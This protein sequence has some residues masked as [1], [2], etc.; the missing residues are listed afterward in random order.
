[1]VDS[2]EIQPIGTTEKNHGML[3]PPLG[4]RA[5]ASYWPMFLCKT[6]NGAEMAKDL[7]FKSEPVG[8][9]FNYFKIGMK[10]EAV[11]RKNPQLI[12][13][14]SVGKISLLI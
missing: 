3:Q 6:L 7:C 14:A 12:C 13:V 10:L 9:K 8:P 1:M 11:D 2:S 5:N 4:Y